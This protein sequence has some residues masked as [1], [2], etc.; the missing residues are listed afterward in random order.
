[1]CRDGNGNH[2]S[3]FLWRISLLGDNSNLVPTMIETRKIVPVGFATTDVMKEY[4]TKKINHRE[5]TDLTWKTPPRRR[6][7]TT[8]AGQQQSHYF[9]V[10][11]DRRRFTMR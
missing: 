10:V 6:G 1:V 5:D 3:D 2:I 8:G 4:D 7:K 11:T 9:R